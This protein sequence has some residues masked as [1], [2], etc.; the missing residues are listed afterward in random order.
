MDWPFSPVDEF[1]PPFLTNVPQWLEFTGIAPLYSSAAWHVGN[2]GFYTPVLVRRKMTVKR[3]Y[4]F[5][6]SVV[7]GNCSVALYDSAYWGGAAP[8]RAGYESTRVPYK[9]LT[10]SGSVAQSGVS[11]WQSF[12]VTDVLLAPGLYWLAYAL[13]NTTGQVTRLAS[14][15]IPSTMYYTWFSTPVMVGGTFPLPDPGN[16]NPLS[17]VDTYEIP[18]LAMGGLA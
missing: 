8:A 9:R 2:E 7:S 17:G 3:L 4:A 11:Q 12:D 14:V 5:N 6:G 1:A 13:D 16:P 18:L 10:A 15:T